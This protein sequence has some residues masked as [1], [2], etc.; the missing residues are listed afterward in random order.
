[1]VGGFGVAGFPAAVRARTAFFAAGFCGAASWRS[2]ASRWCLKP[3]REPG[4]FGL[5]LALAKPLPRS[6]EHTSALQ[7]LMRISDAVFCLKK[8]HK[9]RPTQ[10]IDHYHHPTHQHL[11]QT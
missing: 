4:R 3:R 1:M 9:P 10:P 8:P 7:S 6:E 11:T 5:G 2:A